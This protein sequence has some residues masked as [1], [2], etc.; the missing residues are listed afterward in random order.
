V[1]GGEEVCDYESDE[2]EEEGSEQVENEDEDAASWQVVDE[3]FSR[4]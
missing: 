4:L 1:G 2:L 3:E